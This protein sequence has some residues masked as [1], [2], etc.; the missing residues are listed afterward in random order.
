MDRQMNKNIFGMRNI[1][2]FQNLRGLS[3][4]AFL[5]PLTEAHVMSVHDNYVSIPLA[6]IP[7]ALFVANIKP[8]LSKSFQI[9]QGKISLHPIFS[10]YEKYGPIKI[11]F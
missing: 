2:V 3:E 7:N 10:N 1:V 11:F 5:Y 6:S 9:E 8:F 4:L